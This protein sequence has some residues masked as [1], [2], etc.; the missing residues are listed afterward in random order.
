[1]CAAP[2][3]CATGMKRMPAAGKMS[4]ASMYA[5]PTMPKTSVTPCETSVSTNASDAVIRCLPCTTM[6]AASTG[7]FM[8]LSR[9]PNREGKLS[10]D[11]APPQQ[12]HEKTRCFVSDFDKLEA[13]PHD[14]KPMPADSR[15]GTRHRPSRILA[16]IEPFPD[17]H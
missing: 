7:L 14:A 13:N 6:R 2:C 8:A 5:E 11:R 17:R 3:S 10:T 1:M 12:S 15:P 16:H 4:S 9:L